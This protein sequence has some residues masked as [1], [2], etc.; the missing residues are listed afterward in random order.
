[1]VHEAKTPA[2]AAIASGMVLDHFRVLRPLGSGGMAEVFLAEDVRLGRRVALK[3]IHPQHLGSKVSVR[4]FYVEA[5]ATAKLNHPHIVTIYFIGTHEG[6]PYLALE[7]IEGETLRALMHRGPLH[8]DQVVS[9]GAAIADALAEAHRHH[10]LHRD[11]KPENVI[12]ARDG[13]P[14]VLDFGLAKILQ[15][16][17]EIVRVTGTFRQRL[18]DRSVGHATTVLDMTDEAHLMGSPPYMAPEQWLGAECTPQIDVWALGVMLFEMTIG[19]RPFE[20]PKLPDLCQAVLTQKVCA[21][22]IAPDLSP[23]LVELIDACLAKE[24]ASRP[25]AS[26]VA[27]ALRKLAPTPLDWQ[28]TRPVEKVEKQITA[29]RRWRRKPYLLGAA[30]GLMFLAIGVLVAY[31]VA[32]GAAGRGSYDVHEPLPQHDRAAQPPS[33]DRAVATQPLALPDL[34]P[35]AAPARPPAH[36]APGDAGPARTGVLTDAAPVR[37]NPPRKPRRRRAARPRDSGARP[38]PAAQRPDVEP[39]RFNEL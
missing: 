18:R 20:E 35:A 23:A 17:Q 9:F 25:G 3:V 16:T 8:L 10:V 39:M 22:D 27:A 30:T 5:K 28:E 37:R 26:E 34:E 29:V 1:M 14:R 19:Q 33:P 38:G 4:R 2:E 11:L 12:I 13:R 24:A 32:T 6:C 36:V 7:Y 15:N 21:R 31:F